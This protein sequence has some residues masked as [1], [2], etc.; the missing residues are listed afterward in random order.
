MTEQHEPV[1]PA[2]ASPA[3]GTMAGKG[4]YNLHSRPQHGAVAFGLPLAETAAEAVP[5]PAQGGVLTIADYGVAGGHN[6]MEPVGA[7]LS[8]IRSRPSG[9]GAVSVVHTDLPTNDFDP[10]FTLLASPDSYLAGRSD[11][12]AYVTGGSFYEQLFPAATVDLGWNAI[13]VHWLSSVPV[14]IPDHIWSNCAP[15]TVRQAFATQSADDWRQFL[16]HRTAELVP[17]GQLIVLGGA[18]DDDGKSHA[19]GLMD[20]AN[21]EL[22]MLVEKGTLQPAEY[23]RMVIPTYNRTLAE[24]RAP[25]T[26]GQAPPE[27]QLLS[28]D[29]VTL[30]DPFWAAFAA[31][32]DAKAFAD[33]EVDFFQ[34]AFGP[35]LF[36]ALDQ[37]RPQQEAD[38][39]AA[40]FYAGLGDRAAADP[41]T[42]RCDWRIVNLHLAKHDAA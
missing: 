36:E 2:V 24:F 21:A 1:D 31:N 15:P 25:F 7:M 22:Q 40:A 10:L 42:A 5:L 14:A 18:S 13:A 12:F 35:S 33:A 23:E 38:S 26:D 32:H 8:T 27:L 20:M 29:E 9:E 11:V 39:L 17:G 41:A 3:L 30:D 19:E 28:A 6:S 34:A 37:R 4:Y 16:L